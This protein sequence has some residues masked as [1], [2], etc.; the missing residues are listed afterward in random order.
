MAFLSVK[1]LTKR[2]GGLTALDQFDLDVSRGEIVGIIGPNGSGKTTFFNVLTGV[3]PA[4]E[5]GIYL[6]G[7][8]ESLLMRKTHEIISLGISRT[9]QNQRPFNNLSVLENV[10]VG[11]HCRTRAGI[12]SALLNLRGARKEKTWLRERALD[13]MAIFGDR[14]LSMKDNPAWNLSYANRR[15]LEMAR[16]LISGPKILLLDEPTAGMNPA[17]SQ[18][19]MQNIMSV[20]RSGVTVLVIE[21]DMN[22]IRRLCQRVVALDYGQKI[23][24]GTF[25]EVR[26][27]PRVIEAY[28]GKD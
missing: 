16:A 17:E 18:Q 15:R 28:L 10:M 21:H 11:G 27:H 19:L 6:E 26:N 14:L 9:F 8:S 4:S 23:V 2:F 5:G 12:F 13:T 20:N 1:S 7:V 22:F 25:S 24:E 3:Y